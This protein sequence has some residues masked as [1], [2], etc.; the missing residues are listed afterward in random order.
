MNIKKI[1]YN[2]IV[3]I[4]VIIL[5]YSVTTQFWPRWPTYL[6]LYYQ[7]YIL[8]TQLDEVYANYNGVIYEK[9]TENGV[10]LYIY[11]VERHRKIVKEPY[12]V[13]LSNIELI[14]MFEIAMDH[15]DGANIYM[16]IPELDGAYFDSDR[17]E[18]YSYLNY[19]YYIE[20]RNVFNFSINVRTHDILKE[21]KIE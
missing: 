15:A 6:G 8:N 12:V 11:P 10:N 1:A 13:K 17:S 19:R 3:S 14:E 4:I 7:G 2:I 20:S 18:V 9:L 21:I 5:L 16:S